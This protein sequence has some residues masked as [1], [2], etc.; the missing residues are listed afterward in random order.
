MCVALLKASVGSVGPEGTFLLLLLEGSQTQRD[1]AIAALHACARAFD[2]DL[3]QALHVGGFESHVARDCGEARAWTLALVEKR[4]RDSQIGGG[5]LQVA[6]MPAVDAVTGETPIWEGEGDALAVCEDSELFELV[7][8]VSHAANDPKAALICF[9]RWYSMLLQHAMK[10]L[11][12]TG[13]KLLER[14]CP[15]LS[16]VTFW[17]TLREYSATSISI[18]ILLDQAV[19]GCPSVAL[20]GAESLANSHLQV[21]KEEVD[22]PMLRRLIYNNAAM[23]FGSSLLMGIGGPLTLPIMLPTALA[24]TGI[25]RFRLCLAV[26]ILAELHPLDPLTVAATL[27]CAFN[28]EAYR[29]LRPNW[30]PPHPDDLPVGEV[31]GSRDPAAEWRGLPCVGQGVGTLPLSGED[32]AQ[33]APEHPGEE[34]A[35]SARD[36]LTPR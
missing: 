1:G 2:I 13:E 14:A 26:A 36:Q 23:T 35:A 12:L 11:K 27:C 28:G 9:E 31:A 17:A 20:V 30:P 15:L 29:L 33:A 18:S 4:G 25:L 16:I 8:G 7:E 19:E 5:A 32:M 24:A 22:I 3:G 34:R 6:V 21:Y 10:T